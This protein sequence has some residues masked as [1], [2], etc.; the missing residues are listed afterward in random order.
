MNPAGI[1]CVSGAE[2]VPENCLILAE[3]ITSL[4]RLDGNAEDRI[5]GTTAGMAVGFPLSP[6]MAMGLAWTKPI[7]SLVDFERSGRALFSNT[8]R[9]LEDDPEGALGPEM[10][11]LS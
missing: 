2:S 1:E 10:L 8:T 5:G 11:A 3:G 6:M 9:G 4:L 7:S